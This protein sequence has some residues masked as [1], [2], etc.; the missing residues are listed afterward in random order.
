METSQSSFLIPNS[1]KLFSKNNRK[2]TSMKEV[3]QHKLSIIEIAKPVFYRY[4][5]TYH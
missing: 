2:D 4:F 3:S 1:K 5:D